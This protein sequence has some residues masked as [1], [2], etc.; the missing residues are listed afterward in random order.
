MSMFNPNMHHRRS[1]RWAGYDYRNAGA[2]FVTICTHNKRPIFGCSENE[3]IR[4]HPY[5]QIVAEEWQRTFELRPNCE[6]DDWIVMPN[7]VHAIVRINQVAAFPPPAAAFAQPIPTSLSTLIGAFKS[8]A[9]RRINKHRAARSWSPVQIWQ[10]GF[11][12]RVIRSEPELLAIRQ[13]IQQN[14]ARW[15]AREQSG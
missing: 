10:R 15:T 5:G 2:Y 8:A 14:P 9:T 12:E 11:H 3:T 4:L 7:H 13:Y 1:I 6:M